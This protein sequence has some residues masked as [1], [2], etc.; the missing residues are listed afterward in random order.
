[1]SLRDF[2]GKW[3]SKIKIGSSETITIDIPPEIFYKELA[4]YTATSLIAN[5]ICLCEF[6]VFEDHK[7][8]KNEDYY[9]L[10]V[11]PN[12]NENS[13]LFWHR[14]VQKMIRDPNGAMV[15][16][17]RGQL[18]CAES[19]SVKSE[20]PILGNVYDGITLKGGLQLNRQYTAEEVYLF[21][22]E[23]ENVRRLIDGMYMDYGKLIRSAARAFMDT[24]G[25]KFKFK[26]DAIK[27]GDDEFAEEY[28]NKISKEI[29]R[30]MQNEYATYV[31]YEGEELKEE[32][33]NKQSKS[34]DDIVKLR[35]DYFEMVSGVFKIPQS[36][37]SGNITSVK[38]I[39]DSFLTFAVDPYVDAIT[40]VLNKRA[41]VGEYLKGNYYQC[42]SSKVR[43]HD[44][45]DLADACDKLIASTIMCTDEVREELGL[46]PINE[47]WS[48]QHYV[49][50]NY[51]RV[52]DAA[53]PIEERDIRDEE[54]TE[55]AFGNA[56]E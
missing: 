22:L 15:I 45:F 26:V 8:V 44:L 11:A 20:R 21:K 52:E 23:D 36:L 6:K 49:T 50:N 18:H 24:N 46:T 48:R 56:E 30:Y 16:E 25:R 14:V 1:M 4:V 38:E 17:V 42:S 10:N 13:S 7:P 32:S 34:A 37:M 5:A 40:A 55:M 54:T 27:G 3:I 29:K 12:Q 35:Q 51:S 33:S 39:G 43:H 9:I 41:T 19:Y 28:R 31:E 47:D 53:K 2:L